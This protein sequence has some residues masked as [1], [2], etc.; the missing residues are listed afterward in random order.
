[1]AP[2]AKANCLCFALL[3]QISQR[4]ASFQ[5]QRAPV[6]GHFPASSNFASTGPQQKAL[7]GGGQCIPPGL[8]LVFKTVLLSVG[9]IKNSAPTGSVR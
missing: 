1:M 6:G 8:E 9:R 2:A 5:V 7:F 4:L 3:A